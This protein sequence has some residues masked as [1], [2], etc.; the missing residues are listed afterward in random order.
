MCRNSRNDNQSS[1]SAAWIL[2]ATVLIS[3]P[4]TL[5]AEDS[6]LERV[7]SVP[8]ADAEA[9]NPVARSVFVAPAPGYSSTEVPNQVLYG[10]RMVQDSEITGLPISGLAA[11]STPRVDVLRPASG[12]KRPVGGIHPHAEAWIQ[13]SPFKASVHR[14]Q[15][16]KHQT[17]GPSIPG[18]TQRPVW[19]TP[20][21]YGYFGASGKKHWSRSH[22]YHDRRTQWT[23][24]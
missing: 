16:A 17:A 24:R 20:Y 11:A 10:E 9:A 22:G 15:H 1:L 4:T 3:I 5:L 8:V 2:W 6:N 12:P 13:A 23:L 19:K 21:A 18:A 7:F 14:Q